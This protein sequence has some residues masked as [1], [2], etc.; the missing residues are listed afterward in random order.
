MT[1]RRCL[2]CAV[3]SA[4]FLASVCRA[5]AGALTPWHLRAGWEEAYNDNV[6]QSD[7]PDLDEDVISSF[8]V[9]VEWENP[10]KHSRLPR[11]V[12]LGVDGHVY[13]NVTDF[14]YVEI[15]PELTY[16]LPW[17]IDAEI[18]YVFSPRQ[19]LYDEGGTAEPVFYQENALWAGLVRRFGAER[20]LRAAL[21]FDNDWDDYRDPNSQ[22]DSWT[23]AVLADVRYR[24]DV[25]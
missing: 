13:A 21:G 1:L 16:P 22:R 5:S 19:L 11:A 3:V 10:K 8:G 20:R 12:A 17:R 4:L 18:E 14:N 2:S 24:F 6:R 7:G 9:A 23:P 25:T 15:H